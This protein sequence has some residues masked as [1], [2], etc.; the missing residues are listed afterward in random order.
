MSVPGAPWG[1]KV[2]A[3]GAREIVRITNNHYPASRSTIQ[4]R[5]R[6]R[7]R[8]ISVEDRAARSSPS[9]SAKPRRGSDTPMRAAHAV[10][11]RARTAAPHTK[12]QH[13]QAIHTA[14]RSSQVRATTRRHLIAFLR[15]PARRGPRQSGRDRAAAR[16]AA[17]SLHCAEGPCRAIRPRA[18]VV[19]SRAMSELTS[20][21][22]PRIRL[23][24]S[25][26]AL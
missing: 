9:S 23:P 2:Y 1:R 14:D 11:I 21:D 7:R 24:S 26:V 15:P 18:A 6:P 5:K 3:E 16:W 19:S 8:F 10:T 12:N 25:R 22:E 13:D 4:L 20:G 17:S